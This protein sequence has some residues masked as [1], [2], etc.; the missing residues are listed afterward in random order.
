M[1]KEELSKLDSSKIEEKVP[2]RDQL[3]Y[4]PVDLREC[5]LPP[6]P[7]T[8]KVVNLVPKL[9]NRKNSS[10]F[11]VK[12][13]KEPKFVPYEPYK[14]ATNPIVG[15]KTVK[16]RVIKLVNDTNSNVE[17]LMNLKKVHISEIT[18]SQCLPASNSTEKSKEQA[19]WEEEKKVHLKLIFFFFFF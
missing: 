13:A 16:K 8:G 17:D 18:P 12:F 3:I 5:S 11:N 4:R 6:T 19:D 9:V 2:L 7:I 10:S 1:E 15:N 14:A